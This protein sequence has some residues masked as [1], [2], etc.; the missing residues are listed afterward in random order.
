MLGRL[1]RWVSLF[2]GAVV[3]SQL[4]L[5]AR[6]VVSLGRCSKSAD[7]SAFLGIQQIATG[8]ATLILPFVVLLWSF[9]A[10]I[11][12]L[13]ERMSLVARQLGSIAVAI[14]TWWVW[15]RFD[16]CGFFDWWFE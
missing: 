9:L 2:P 12:V 14:A 7:G 10:L 11:L 8:I 13:D 15:Y 3:A 6:V 1:S 5:E 4:L 16:P